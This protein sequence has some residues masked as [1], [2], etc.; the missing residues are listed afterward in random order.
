MIRGD[1]TEKPSTLTVIRKRIKKAQPGTVFAAFDF[2]D[3]GE[4]TNINAHLAVLA[5]EGMLFALCVACITILN[6]TNC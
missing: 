6:M 3:V 2:V 4:K 1:D 5:E